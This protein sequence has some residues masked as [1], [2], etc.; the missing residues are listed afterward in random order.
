MLRKPERI[1]LSRTDSIGDVML[2]L[3]CAGLLKEKFPG[4]QVIFLG[5]SYTR[6]VIEA[7][8]HVD[9]FVDWDALSRLP[10]NEAVSAFKILNANSIVHVFPRKQIARLAKKAGITR[11]I[12]TTGRLFHWLTCNELV[13]FSRKRSGLHEAQLNVKLLKPF[14][15]VKEYS[16]AELA[17]K[18]GFTRIKPLPRQFREL[19]DSDKFNLIIHPG[20]QGSAR[21]WGTENFSRLINQLPQ[22]SYRIFVTGTKAEGESLHGFISSHPQLIDLTG[23]LSLDE[24]ISF[25]AAADGLVA[26]STGPLHI[27]AALDKKATGLFAPMRPIHPGRWAPLG[28]QARFLVLDKD[29]EACRKSK[30]CACIRSIAPDEV[31]EA[32]EK[33]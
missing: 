30:D 27:A 16:T 2:T 6:A 22:E 23:K 14:G 8:E 13:R 5:K 33:R 9:E 17:A 25:I 26:A 28:K 18:Y 31:K 32:L 7:C 1:I 19:I 29:C 24:L 12:G 4:C 21:E 3:P 20:S 10:E 11:R 15:I